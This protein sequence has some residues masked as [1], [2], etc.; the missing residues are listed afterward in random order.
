M[1]TRQSVLQWLA[2]RKDG[3]DEDEELRKRVFHS[4]AYAAT[5]SGARMA[6]GGN[7]M[8]FADRQRVEAER[9]HVQAYQNSRLIG[10]AGPPSMAKTYTPPAPK[11]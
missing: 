3:D 9:K 4:S 5:E 6:T 10:N 7:G 2:K 1:A 8:T 11:S